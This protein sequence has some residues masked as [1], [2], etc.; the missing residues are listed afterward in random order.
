LLLECIMSIFSV[1][2]LY[3]PFWLKFSFKLKYQLINNNCYQNEISVII[4]TTHFCLIWNTWWIF[5]YIVTKYCMPLKV[6]VNLSAYKLSQFTRVRSKWIILSNYLPPPYSRI[7]ASLPMIIL[8]AH[9]SERYVI[10]PRFRTC[11]S[12]WDMKS[13]D[14]LNELV[15]A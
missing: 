10:D 9:A 8:F 1:L 13:Y 4:E 6:W 12:L 3:I 14:V 5:C 11:C 7:K 15:E 2:H